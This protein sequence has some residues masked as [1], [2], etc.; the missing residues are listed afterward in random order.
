MDLKNMPRTTRGNRCI[1]A[2]TEYNTRFVGSFALP[3]SQA[4]MIARIIVDEICLRYIEALCLLSILGTNSVSTIVAEKRKLFK[5]E[6]V[7]ATPYHPKTN[8]LV[9]KFNEI[10][11]L[12]LAM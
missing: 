2:F 11:C 8:A 1:L 9:E 3:N 6:R 4:Y 10:L 12:N 5:I 7:H